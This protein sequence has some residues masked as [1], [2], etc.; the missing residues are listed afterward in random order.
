MSEPVLQSLALILVVMAC[1]ATWRWPRAYHPLTLMRQLSETMARRVRP[2]ADYS[3]SQH[4]LSGI[5]GAAVLL[6]PLL[7][8][9]ALLVNMAEYPVFFEGLILLAILDFGHDRK[10]Y[11]QVRSALNQEKK[12]LAR[13]RL[14]LLVARDTDR[15]SPVGIAKAAIEAL[16]LRFCYIYGA[17]VF[18]FLL[19][20]PVA[21]LTYRL[22]LMLSW[23]WHCRRPGFDYFVGPVQKLTRLLAIVPAWL[24]TF[25][26]I[27]VTHPIDAIQAARRSPATDSTSLLLALVGGALGFQL[28]GPAIYQQQKFRYPRVGGPREVRLSDV[29]RAKHA[30]DRTNLLMAILLLLTFVTCWPLGWS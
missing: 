25:L 29:S 8:L 23:Q 19:A 10:A 3:V 16:F 22:L 13:D 5:L 21:A 2:G 17:V 1:D 7:V 20:G 6:G 24:T 9:L 15:L 30:I 18:W 26:L 14:R 27:L 11:R 12:M 28:G 4:R